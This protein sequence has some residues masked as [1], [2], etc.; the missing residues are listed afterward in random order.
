MLNSLNVQQV[1]D[2]DHSGFTLINYTSR[3]SQ[4]TGCYSFFLLFTS[5][6]EHFMSHYDNESAI[7]I[8]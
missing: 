5:F 4:S 6:V 2:H 3:A 7:S 8:I 1:V